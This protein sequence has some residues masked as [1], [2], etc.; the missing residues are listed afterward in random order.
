MALALVVCEVN[1]Y[2][3]AEGAISSLVMSTVDFMAFI[4]AV[5]IVLTI[6]GLGVVGF[7][8]LIQSLIGYSFIE[9]S[10][11]RRIIN[12]LI[13]MGIV[14]GLFTAVLPTVLNAVGLTQ[15][16]NAM[17]SFMQLVFKHLTSLV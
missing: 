13:T 2:A 14:L 9:W 15:M 17:S 16:A 11:I 10:S 6:G 5:L 7:L 8:A 12:A 3:A 4:A 1:P